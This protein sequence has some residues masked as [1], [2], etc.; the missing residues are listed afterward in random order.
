MSGVQLLTQNSVSPDLNVLLTPLH[1]GEVNCVPAEL[2]MLQISFL[3][4]QNIINFEIA[5]L[6]NQIKMIDC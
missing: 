2:E 5:Q 3:F 1:L 6:Q 4:H